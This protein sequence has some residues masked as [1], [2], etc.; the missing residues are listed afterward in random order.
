MVKSVL[1]AED[2]ALTRHAICSVFISQED[3]EVCADAENGQEAFE[4]AQV[5]RPDLIFRCQ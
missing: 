4:M 2:H 1:V 3:F 5:L